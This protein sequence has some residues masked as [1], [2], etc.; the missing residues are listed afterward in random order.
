MTREWQVSVLLADPPHAYASNPR[1]T[2]MAETT[3]EIY[4]LV[5]E[6]YPSG[7]VMGIWPVKP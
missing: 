3:A 1:L 5:R 4:A 7:V 6:Q 2:V